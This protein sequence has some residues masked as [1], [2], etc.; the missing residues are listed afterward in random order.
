MS[1]DRARSSGP[2]TLP[3]RRSEKLHEPA[4]CIAFSRVHP[5]YFL[6]GTYV[7]H[8]EQ[9]QPKSRGDDDDDDDDAVST[10]DETT[11]AKPIQRRTGSVMLWADEGDELYACFFC[12][13]SVL[14][15]WAFFPAPLIPPLIGGGSF[16]SAYS[17][18]PLAGSHSAVPA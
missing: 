10:V 12:N 17:V 9:Q 1:E 2:L 18:P 14:C 11:T 6:V 15:F 16:R 4:T 5:K 13:C 8:V 7:L 3:S